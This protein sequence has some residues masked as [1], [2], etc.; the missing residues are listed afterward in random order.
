[1]ADEFW[2][3]LVTR[4]L[5]LSLIFLSFVVI[6]GIGGMVSLAQAT[7][8]TCAGLTTGVLVDAGVGFFPAA[9]LGIAAAVLLGLLV[10]VPSLR[11]GGLPLA[12]ATL[13]LAF[14]GDRVLFAWDVLGNGALGWTIPRPNIGPIELVDDR[15]FAMGLLVVIGIVAL[16]IRNVSR[17]ASGRGMSAVRSTEVA[18]RSVG[19]SPTASKLKL[20]AL[21]AAIA[22]LGGV[23]LVSFDRHAT[24]SATPAVTGLLWVATVVLLGVR[25]IGG[26]VIA[27]LVSVL[28]PQI[29]TD[30]IH[31]PSPVPSFLSWN[32]TKSVYLAPLLFGLGAVQLARD[33]DGLL[34]IVARRNYARRAKRRQRDSERVLTGIRRAE[35]AAVA[36][37]IER[38]ATLIATTG[39]V[40]SASGESQPIGKRGSR[41]RALLELI[42]VRACYGDVEVLHG[43]S[44][45]LAQAQITALIGANGAGKSTL[46]SVIAG[47]VR[48]SS[49]IVKFDGVDI[50]GLSSFRRARG[51]VVFA[52]ET[53]G[54]FPGLSVDENLALWLRAAS[55]RGIAY[56]KFPLLYQRRRQMAGSL[57]GG[58]QQ[59]LT[60]APLFARPPTVLVADEPTLG[61]APKVVAQLMD[62]FQELRDQGVTVL[63]V[64]ER[65]GHILEI[66]RTVVIMEL[67]HI[68]WQGPRAEIDLHKIADSYLGGDPLLR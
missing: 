68:L 13:A 7:F 18:A 61:L 67:G 42:D 46:C 6:T 49:G 31:F 66:A 9:V 17:S 19:I 36:L 1:L 20:F 60:L 44:V 62:L 24:S 45:G 27:G 38:H 11:L 23:F 47:S 51:G 64:E 21:S 14:V 16:V 40:Q 5:A 30:G 28:F 15:T 58:E 3:G 55:D 65:A 22:G 25:R 4:G 54:I 2:L 39:V 41:T 35:E 10:A 50:T 32:G 43:V 48:P 59:M 52:P 53:R 8:V 33:P 26:A 37:D 34:S 56:D 63:L 57:S 12:L 29:L